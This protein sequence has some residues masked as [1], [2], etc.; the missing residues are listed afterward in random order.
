M[1]DQ[2]ADVAGMKEM[3]LANGYVADQAIAT[4]VFLALTLER[5]LLLEG[6]AGVGKTEIANTIAAALDLSLIH[7]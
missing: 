7:I 6:E 2:P 5:P 3:L 4:A 1:V